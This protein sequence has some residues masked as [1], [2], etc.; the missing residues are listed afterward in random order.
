VRDPQP[1]TTVLALDSGNKAAYENL[2]RIYYDR[3]H[4]KDKS[5]LVLEGSQQLGK[6]KREQALA[7]AAELKRVI[8]A[9][10]QALADE[11]AAATPTP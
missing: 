2:A 4:S 8:A 7:D 5:Y 1:S 6:M 11:A 9:E 3:G 10:K